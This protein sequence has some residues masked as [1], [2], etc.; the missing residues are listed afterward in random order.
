MYPDTAL[1]ADRLEQFIFTSEGSCDTDTIWKVRAE[2]V[3][4]LQNAA[5]AA[6]IQ[7]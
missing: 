2:S 7:K 5:A 1:I 4:E 3:P 6:I